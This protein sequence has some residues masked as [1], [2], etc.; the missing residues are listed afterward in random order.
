VNVELER[1][2]QAED[3][4]CEPGVVAARDLRGWKRLRCRAFQLLLKIE[5]K[6]ALL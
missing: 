4:S 2:R 3:P 6:V 1:G 5:L